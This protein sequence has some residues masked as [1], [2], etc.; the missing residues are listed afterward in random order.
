MMFAKSPAIPPA[1][2]SSRARSKPLPVMIQA[3]PGVTIPRLAQNC[4]AQRLLDTVLGPKGLQSGKYSCI[5]QQLKERTIS[6]RGISLRCPASEFQ[7]T[8]VTLIRT[9]GL[10][11]PD[12]TPCGQ[13]VA[14]AEAHALIE[15]SS[16]PG[17][18][19][20]GLAARLQLEKSSVSRIVTALEKRGWVARKRNPQ[21]TRIVHVHLTDDG[22]DAASTLAASR[23]AKF[24][25]IF[26]A[27]PAAEREAVLASLDT[28]LQV[29]RET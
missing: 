12:R 8:M 2:R 5:V 17:L 25:R 26:A 21:D 18:S 11:R 14:V 4:F 19:Q 23:Q 9:L 3:K 13:P 29:I 27:I 20:N 16:E 6:P 22:R 15:L 28:L 1:L 10:H 24:E 7:A